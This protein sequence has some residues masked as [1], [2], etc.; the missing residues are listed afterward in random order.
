MP[1]PTPTPEIK[2]VTEA[3]L[4]YL[5]AVLIISWAAFFGLALFLLARQRALKREIEQLRQQVGEETPG[6]DKPR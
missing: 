2:F 1:T 5:F 6:P 4:G 3:N